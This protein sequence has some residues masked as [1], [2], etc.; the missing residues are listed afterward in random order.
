MPDLS[1]AELAAAIRA[2]Q[3]SPLEA[4][5][6]CLDRIER[7]DG[8][9]MAFITVDADGALVA[10]RAREAE[11]DA[12]QIKGELHG[13][14]L[15]HKDL[16]RIDPLPTSC[17][18]ATADY[19][20]ADQ[21]C[22]AVRRLAAAGA[23]TLGKLNMSE[24]AMGPFG[25]NAHHGDA[26]NPW[27]LGHVTGGSSSGSAAAVAGGLAFGALGSDTGGSIR[28]PAACCGLVGFKPTYGRVSRAGAMP[29][30]WSLDHLG[31]LTRTV[32]DAALLLGLVAGPDPL[33]S[34]ASRRPVP[35]YLTGL[36]GGVS[37][38]RVALLGGFFQDG[39]T[40]EVATATQAVAER[41]AALGARLGQVNP[42]DPEL[43]ADVANVIARSE[44]AAIHGRLF[45]ERPEQLQPAVYTRLAV[46]F[47][48]SAVQYLQA[49][50]LRAGLTREFIREAFA[51]AD[52]LL[53]PTIPEPAPTL[54]SVKAGSP[55]EIAARMGRFSRLT[56]PFNTLGLPAIAVP[57]G[58]SAQGLPLSV[59]IVGRPWA[60]PTVLR[61]ARALEAALGRPNRA[62]E[63]E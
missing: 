50:R 54:A 5:R 17:G 8:R 56:R 31:P 57:C 63:L 9:L 45:R 58:F 23:I 34:T 39:L 44:S 24:L 1:L 22:T 25:D 46:G 48:I 41:F 40:A 28:L 2:R 29:L 21:D 6:D 59:Q 26:N 4:T 55:D 38:L 18:T 42:P 7:F 27:R 36:E 33:D 43:L 15:A 10:A 19:F 49:L 30:S 16:C 11:L 13:V 20:Q 32:R 37:G 52:L 51:N 3:I 47:E 53:C 12:G 35:D 60:E 61:A 62:P 14:P